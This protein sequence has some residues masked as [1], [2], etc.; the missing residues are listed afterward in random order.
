MPDRRNQSPI[1]SDSPTSDP[2]RHD[3]CTVLH[4]SVRQPNRRHTSR[5]RQ[6]QRP[7]TRAVTPP[8]AILCAGCAGTPRLDTS[9]PSR[10]PTPEMQVILSSTPPTRL[11]PARRTNRR[12]AA[13]SRRHAPLSIREASGIQN[14]RARASKIR[15]LTILRRSRVAGAADCTKAAQCGAEM[16]RDFAN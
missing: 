10:P 12:G 6:D 11:M 4:A 9:R 3:R 7:P 8:A 5:T 13:R 15:D 16:L 2:T 14:P 1:S